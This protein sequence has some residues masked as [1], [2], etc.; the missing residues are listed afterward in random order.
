MESGIM[1]TFVESR[2]SSKLPQ[3][4]THTHTSGNKKNGLML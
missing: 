4:H 1:D 3:E 2:L